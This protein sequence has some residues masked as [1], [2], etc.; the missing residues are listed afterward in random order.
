M[1][2]S[3]VR[4]DRLHAVLCDTLSFISSNILVHFSCQGTR[5]VVDFEDIAGNVCGGYSYLYYK[6]VFPV[7]GR[8]FATLSYRFKDSDGVWWTPNQSV[9]IPDIIP[10]D[11]KHGRVRGTVFTGGYKVEPLGA[12]RCV[13][14]A[15]LEFQ[16]VILFLCGSG[17]GTA[18]CVAFCV[19][20]GCSRTKADLLSWHTRTWLAVFQILLRKC[21]LKLNRQF[22]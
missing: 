2:N 21:S 10:L 15:S 5:R 16:H 11:T 18:L 13:F 1:T 20:L 6:K 4:D 19:A 12:V 22:V 17:V 7:A 8:D 3:K 9:D 14:H